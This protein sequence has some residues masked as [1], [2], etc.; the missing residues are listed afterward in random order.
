M[1]LFRVLAWA[2]GVVLLVLIF[3]AVPLKYFADQ[4][5][6]SAVA[7]MV[8]GIVLYPAYV[9]V[10]F[11]LGYR[12]RWSLPRIVLVIL[13]GTV[14]FMSFVAER[15]VVADLRREQAGAPAAP[16]PPA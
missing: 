2:T 14:P 5:G 7:G 9:I 12:A 8:H 13:A 16:G 1:T 3:V 10:S 4:G 11:V 6:L 15:A